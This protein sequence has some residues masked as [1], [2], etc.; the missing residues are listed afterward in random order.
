MRGRRGRACAAAAWMALGLLT[1][2]AADDR[3]RREP[4]GPYLN[5]AFPPSPPSPSG[6]WAA[7]V[8]FPRLTFEDPLLLVPD[9][10]GGRLYVGSRQGTVWSIADDPN[11]ATKSVFLDLRGRCQGYDDG[12]L[13]AMAF[14]P[15][16]GRPGAAE[17]GYVY[18][19]YNYS[20]SPHPGPDRPPT[21]RPTRDRLSRFT[22]PDGSDA[23]DPNSEL[24]LI[25]QLDE[26]MWHN[27]GGMF[28]HADDGFLY[29]SLGDEGGDYGNTQRVD[30]DL[31]SGVIRIDVDRRGG[32]VS[33]PPP[34]QPRSGRTAHYFIPNDNPWVGRPDTLEEFWCI[35][36]R[37]PHRMTYDPVGK[38]VW[39]GDVG[40]STF[41]EI[42]LIERG[43]NYQWRYREG[44]MPGP[45][46]RPAKPLGEEKSPI[47]QYSHRE[48][49]AIIGGY[50]YR[51]S[52]HA[53]S[54][55]GK[56]VFGDNGGR[57][58]AMTYDDKSP[59]HVEVLCDMPMAASRSYGLGLSSFGAG[60][61][62]ELYLCQ[63]GHEGRIYR[64]A[65]TGHAVGSLPRTLSKTGAF[66]DLKTLKPASGLVAYDVNSPLWSD[67]AAKSRWVAVPND[68]LPYGPSERVAFAE[69]GSWSFPDGTVFV[70]HFELADGSALRRLE[71][72]F[73]VRSA[74]GGAY[75]LTYRWRPDG[76]DAD[77]IDD[78][79]D[80]SIALK[81]SA[82][83]RPQTWHYPGRRECLMCHTTAAG[84]VLGVSTRQLN[85]GDQLAVLSRLGLFDRPIESGAVAGLPRLAAIDEP[86]APLEHRVRS[87]LDS[88]CAHCHRPGAVRAH[89][90]ATYEAASS[91][92]GL[93][94][95]EVANPLGVAGAR[96]IVAGE[97]A[98]SIAARRVASTDPAIRMPPLA[99]NVVDER[100]NSAIRDWITSLGPRPTVRLLRPTPHALVEGG[101]AVAIEADVVGVPPA[102]GVEFFAGETR[103]GTVASPPFHLVWKGAGVGSY[104]LSARA[105]DG[106]GVA[107]ASDG[108]VI[109]VVA[110]SG[111]ADGTEVYL[112]DVRWRAATSGYGPIERDRSNGEQGGGDGRPI[113]IGGRDYARGLGVHA[114]SRIDYQLDGAYT[115]FLADVGVDDEAGETGTVTFEVWADRVKLLDTG[116]MRGGMPAR[117]VRVDL[118]GRSN[119][120]LIVTDAGDGNGCDH[121]DWA[122]ARLVRRPGAGKRQVP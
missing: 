89:F 85:R 19:F 53:A 51:G 16:F 64:L 34:R 62:G 20:A 23:A 116:P 39:L 81:T 120:T 38:R 103:I 75:G 41:E 73:L 112:S 10:R 55:G 78:G 48:G 79:S 25:D 84:Y 18:I 70:K 1:H 28:F 74:G 100:A 106:A 68:G 12:G 114:D 108:V 29:L 94:D 91:S 88:N 37:S 57:I 122:D 32:P 30:K 46:A 104:S 11:S 105:V 7:V 27:G 71:T 8:A 76:S 90:D 43:G 49:S 118:A 50:V 21:T 35:G 66:R 107:S 117:E 83:E 72:R 82:G 3:P 33:H 96:V 87:Y 67:G 80:E 111:K 110:P 22:V 77:L 102:R 119:L 92:A 52:E 9:P 115:T 63:L 26:N 42:D 44:T 31:F 13:L 4:I 93:V 99:S 56:Y 58:W 45:D 59:P 17:R 97:P 86:G 2:A 69:L 40:E 24:V 65:R 60:P 47:H 113:S 109:T 98:R 14:H 15:R 36:L 95:A 54:L 101:Q 6:G 5:G 61:D 121:A